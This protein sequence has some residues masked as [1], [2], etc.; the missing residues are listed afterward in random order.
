M[1]WS[2]FGQSWRGD[3]PSVWL[4]THYD[5]VACHPTA[6]SGPGYAYAIVCEFVEVA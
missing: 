2:M 5:L 3:Y 6:L 4:N 1:T